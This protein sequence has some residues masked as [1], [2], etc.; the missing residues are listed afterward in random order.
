MSAVRR[1]AQAI[2]I[3]QEGGDQNQMD[4]SHAGLCAATPGPRGS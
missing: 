3:D 1:L 4:P 2:N